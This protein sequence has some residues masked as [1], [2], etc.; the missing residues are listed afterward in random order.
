MM[1]LDSKFRFVFFGPLVMLLLINSGCED[2][3]SETITPYQHW[4]L[5]Y[6]LSNYELRPWDHCNL[7]SFIDCTDDNTLHEYDYRYP[8]Y[9]PS[10]PNE[11]AYLR[12]LK[13]ITNENPYLGDEIWIFN[14]ETGISRKLYTGVISY[15]DWQ[16]DKLLFVNRDYSICTIDSDG[17]NLHEIIPYNNCVRYRSIYWTDTINQFS[18]YSNTQ[19]DPSRFYISDT[20]GNLKDSVSLDG[21]SIKSPNAINRNGWLATLLP[22]SQKEIEIG[23]YAG[24]SFVSFGRV[25]GP[26]FGFIGVYYASWLDEETMFW[27][28]GQRSGIT[29]TGTGETKHLLNSNTISVRFERYD[30]SPDGRYVL[31]GRETTEGADGSCVIDRYSQI[32]ILDTHTGEERWIELE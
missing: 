17:H 24:E 11:F 13:N 30:V 16:E 25:E 10:N 3:S 20:D 19:F 26:D 7:C 5:R 14:A 32:H 28:T 27:H 8:T 1:G 18:Y 6:E 4:S 9:H 31:F 22:I 21:I 23:Y 2:D 12:K 29:N 15:L